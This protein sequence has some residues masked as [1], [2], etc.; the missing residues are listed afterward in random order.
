MIWFDLWIG[1]H[2]TISQEQ[3]HSPMKSWGLFI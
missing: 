1:Q 3:H 2:L